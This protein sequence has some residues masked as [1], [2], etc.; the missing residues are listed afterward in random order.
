MV[1]TEKLETILKDTIENIKHWLGFA[2][3]KN[4][5]LIAFDA[6][7]LVAILSNENLNI[8]LS[9]ISVGIIIS[10]V[11]TIG[12]LSPLYRKINIKTGRKKEDDNLLFYGTISKYSS[13]EY[14]TKVCSVYL[15]EEINYAEINS[16]YK[17]YAKEIVDNATI[18]CWKYKGFGYGL[19]IDL[20][21]LLGLAV[22]IILKYV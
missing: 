14:L 1:N 21:L 13:K 18:T 11:V 22:N 10:M 12:T 7:L 2:E 5:A 15:Q 19:G 9:C 20:L 8:M 16:L 6:V 4:A 3:A 17:D